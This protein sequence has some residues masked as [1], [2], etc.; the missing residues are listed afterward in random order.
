MADWNEWQYEAKELAA[1]WRGGTTTYALA[2]LSS[3]DRARHSYLMNLIDV[4]EFE[5]RVAV[6]LQHEEQCDVG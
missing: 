6:A 3:L 2:R 5:M 4:Q 1:K